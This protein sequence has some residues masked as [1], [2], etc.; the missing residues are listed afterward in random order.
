MRT[1]SQSASVPSQAAHSSDA[2]SVDLDLTASGSDE[3]G[4]PANLSGNS[5]H[6]NTPVVLQLDPKTI[7]QKEPN[8]LSEA[9]DSPEFQDLV[10][11]ILNARGNTVPIIVQPLPPAEKVAGSP[12]QYRWFSG[13]RRL[14]ACEVAQ[15]PVR[16]IVQTTSMTSHAAIDRLLEN[17]LREPLSPYEL[18]MQ[19]LHIQALESPPSKRGLARLIGMDE[20]QVLKAIDIAQLPDQVLAAFNSPS[21]IR[22]SDAKPLKD[23]CRAAPDAVI[24]EA[25]LIQDENGLKPAEVVKRLS[26]AAAVSSEGQ[27]VEPFNTPPQTQPELPLEIDGKPYGKL[28]QDKKGKPVISLDVTL[29]PA[30]QAALGKAIEAFLRRRLFRSTAAKGPSATAQK[31]TSPAKAD[32]SQ[33]TE[34]EATE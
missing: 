7:E 28:G 17:H 31:K 20:G 27:G 15:L 23:A 8:R 9:F 1:A 34:S 22:Y 10:D 30:Q 21:D 14:K 26:Q 3:S 19:L 4:K 32:K 16:A 25:E 24:K 5:T 11:S 29:S 2:T 33:A 18:G 12:I 6:S 13:A